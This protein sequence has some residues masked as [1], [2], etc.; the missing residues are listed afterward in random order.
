MPPGD[1]LHFVE[2]CPDC[3]EEFLVQ[4]KNDSEQRLPDQFVA[5][6]EVR[7]AH[8]LCSG[9]FVLVI[10]EERMERQLVGRG[11]DPSGARFR[12]VEA[13][14]PL[15]LVSFRVERAD[16]AELRKVEGVSVDGS[17]CLRDLIKKFIEQLRLHFLPFRR[18][19]PVLD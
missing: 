11:L 6:V 8:S 16:L 4:F 10:F 14:S 9:G 17:H 1:P 15:V 12:V 5:V 13:F 3:L 2:G 7:Q 19:S 18:Q